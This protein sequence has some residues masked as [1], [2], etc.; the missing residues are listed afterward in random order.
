MTKPDFK[1]IYKLY[2]SYGMNHRDAFANAT[3]DFKLAMGW[4]R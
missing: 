4:I 3:E 1:T 2:R